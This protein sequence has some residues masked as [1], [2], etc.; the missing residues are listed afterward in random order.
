VRPSKP[1]KPKVED[2]TGI[3]LKRGKMYFRDKEVPFM[4][5]AAA[6]EK[7]FEFLLK[8]EKPILVFHNAKF[9]VN[10]LYKTCKLE[11]KVEILQEAVPGFIDS[12]T[13]ARGLVTKG[14]VK[15]YDLETLAKSLL[16]R[17]SVANL[18]SADVDVSLLSDVVNKIT[19][20]KNDLQK[21]SFVL[22]EYLK[23]QDLCQNAAKLQPL[24][25]IKG[26]KSSDL[27]ILAQNDISCHDLRNLSSKGIDEFQKEV[28]RMLPKLDVECLVQMHRFLS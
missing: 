12:L 5:A 11:G 8:H 2:L 6:L 26:L 9:D 1:I 18:H 4:S 25:E 19:S 27:T 15:T 7:L 13:A 22:G 28:S 20:S 10:L 21:Y 3:K 14:L 16:G 17:T 23:F 24:L